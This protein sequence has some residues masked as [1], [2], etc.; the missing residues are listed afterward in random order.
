M[1]LRT[2]PSFRFGTNFQPRRGRLVDVPVGGPVRMLFT[3]M[4]HD[5]DRVTRRRSRAV[6]LAA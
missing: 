2:G 4:T 5:A 6:M 1:P 3:P